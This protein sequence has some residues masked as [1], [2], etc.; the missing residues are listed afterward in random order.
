MERYNLDMAY[1]KVGTYG[2]IQWVLTFV[3][4]VFRNSGNFIYY[5]FAYL[6]LEQ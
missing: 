3:T 4:A 1:S 5:T 2:R 6:V